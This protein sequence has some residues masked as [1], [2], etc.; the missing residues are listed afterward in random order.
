MYP[1]I[2]GFAD[3]WARA[4]SGQAAAALPKSVMNSRRLIRLP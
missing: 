3:D 2:G 4:V 1:I